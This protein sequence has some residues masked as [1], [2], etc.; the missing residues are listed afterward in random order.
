MVYG[1]AVEDPRINP[2]L[3]ADPHSLP[4]ETSVVIKRMVTN[5]NDQRLGTVER[6]RHRRGRTI[7]AAFGAEQ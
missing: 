2:Y 3:S 6:R 1:L 4:P 7:S 5:E